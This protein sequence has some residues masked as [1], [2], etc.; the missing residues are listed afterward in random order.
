MA[1][2]RITFEGVSRRRRGRVLWWAA[3]GVVLL[4]VLGVVG[5]SVY[6]GWSLTHA[7]PR[8][9]DR[10]PSEFGLAFEAV[11]FESS[12]GITLRGW[13]IPA[14]NGSGTIIFAHGYRGNRLELGVPALG[15]ARS[16]VESGFNVLL[17]DFRNS[18]ESEGDVTTLGYHEVKDIYGAVEWLKRERAD[19][20][21]KIGVIGFSMGA[22][23]AILAAAG[24]PRVEAVV[25]DSPFSDL[26]SYLSGNMRIWTGLPDVPFTWTILT[27]LPPLLGVEVDAVSP[28]AVIPELEQPVLL[29]HTDGDDTIPVAESEILAAA[30]RPDR[31][32]LWV[33]SGT[34]H[35]GARQVDPAA[36][37]SR[38]IEFFRRA[39]GVPAEEPAAREAD[40]D[41]PFSEAALLVDHESLVADELLVEA[42]AFTEAAAEPP[43]GPVAGALVAGQPA[44]A[45]AVEVE[46]VHTQPIETQPVEAQPTQARSTQVQRVEAQRVEAQPAPEEPSDNQ[47]VEPQPAEGPAAEER[48][49]EQQSVE[50][51]PAEGQVAQGEP[52]EQEPLPSI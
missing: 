3:G 30:G 22:V 31:T 33:V 35:V 19:Q 17:F 51:Q 4:A 50:E 39:L 14:E 28:R 16:L 32:E 47:F 37:D 1:L 43:G 15:L 6:V 42:S 25:A 29:V 5:V 27:L 45:E 52:A 44:R 11:E 38:V 48:A 10:D 12:D 24:E 18:G 40:G 23:T 2:G 34:R 13:F 41:Q 26:R 7:E 9:V 36:Y 21:E 8:P 46:R 20:A 49:A